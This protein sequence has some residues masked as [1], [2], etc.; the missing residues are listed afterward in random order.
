MRCAS[1]LS[2]HPVPAHA[3]GDVIGDVL[4]QPATPSHATPADLALIF[5]TPGFA[6]ASEDIMAAIDSILSPKELLFVVSSGVIGAGSEVCR[7]PAISI[8]LYWGGGA[9]GSEELVVLDLTAGVKSIDHATQDALC[10]SKALVLLG[11]PDVELVTQTIDEVCQKLPHVALSGALLSSANGPVHILDR[12]GNDYGFVAIAFRNSSIEVALG[13]GSVALTPALKVTNSVGRMLCE[14]NGHSALEYA[15]RVIASCET[16]MR[17][18]TARDLAVAILDPLTGAVIDVCRVLGGDRTTGALALSSEIPHSSI[19]SLHRQ[20]REGATAGLQEALGGQHSLGAL[21]F[22][23]CA[24]DPE[25]EREGAGGLSM[26]SDAIG[27]GAFAGAHASAVIGS[28]SEQPGLRAAPL[29]A[30]I[31]GRDHH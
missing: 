2:T 3:V 1:A 21:V 25:S 4:Q 9:I 30:A 20:D 5:T 26:L 29:S 17:A 23:S 28:G 12:H 18:Q 10:E 22:A 6:G 7:G 27:S 8:W 15:Q 14:I 24:I 16:E 11:N 19:V 13:H 31:F